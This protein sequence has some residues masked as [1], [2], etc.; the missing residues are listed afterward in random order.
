MLQR[1]GWSEG[2]GLGRKGSGRREHVKV[3]RRCDNAGVCVCVC[4]SECHCV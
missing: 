1:M 4:V 2:D 3:T